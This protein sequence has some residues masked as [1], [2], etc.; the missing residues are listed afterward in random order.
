V[1]VLTRRINSSHFP[2]TP[3]PKQ[4]CSLRE[5]LINHPSNNA[6]ACLETVKYSLRHL[7]GRPFAFKLDFPALDDTIF[8]MNDAAGLGDDDSFRGGGSWI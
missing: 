8:I 7:E 2:T 4:W 3:G 1:P 5:T 6:G